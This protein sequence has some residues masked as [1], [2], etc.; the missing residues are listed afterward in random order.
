MENYTIPITVF[1]K[2]ILSQSEHSIAS[3]NKR[4]CGAI[5]EFLLVRLFEVFWGI[6]NGEKLRWFKTTV[7]VSPM[8]IASLPSH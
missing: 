2:R 3:E 6:N 7:P 1:H 5:S 8:W 4:P